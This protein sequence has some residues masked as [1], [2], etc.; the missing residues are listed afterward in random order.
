MAP[1]STI[2]DHLANITVFRYCA[3]APGGKILVVV[4]AAKPELFGAA[5]R[6]IERGLI[7]LPDDS[8]RDVTERCAMLVEGSR[9]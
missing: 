5:A 9:P 2:A 6:H 3:D 4:Q 7:F 8:V 1:K